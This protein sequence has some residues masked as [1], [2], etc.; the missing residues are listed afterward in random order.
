MLLYAVGAQ[1][2]YRARWLGD[3]RALSYA[4]SLQMPNCDE[5]KRIRNALRGY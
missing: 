4:E 3:S 5:Y 1:M 2:I